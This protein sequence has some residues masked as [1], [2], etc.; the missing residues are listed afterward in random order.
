M[1]AC[2]CVCV[3]AAQ[4]DLFM[5]NRIGGN[6]SILSIPHLCPIGRF[7]NEALSSLD[8]AVQT[9]THTLGAVN[10]V[11]LG[12]WSLCSLEC[13][14][15]NTVKAVM[16]MCFIACARVCVCVCA[17]VCVLLGF[18]SLAKVTLNL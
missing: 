4:A 7:A 2:L 9:N 3:R 6:N 15:T 17:Y 1:R 18:F 16:M 12:V 14:K 11:A 8:V 13:S 5:M 10:T